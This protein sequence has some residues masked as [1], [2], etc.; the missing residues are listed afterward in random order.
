MMEKIT[1]HLGGMLTR[2]GF[3]AW[4]AMHVNIC[5]HVLSV[6]NLNMCTTQQV[7]MLLHLQILSDMVKIRPLQNFTSISFTNL[8]NFAT[9]NLIKS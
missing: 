4:A 5:A 2:D 1:H 7:I 8:T 3:L 9:Y 6:L